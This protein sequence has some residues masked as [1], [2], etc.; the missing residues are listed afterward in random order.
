MVEVP[1][2][3]PAAA[4]RRALLGRHRHPV[5]VGL[6]LAVRLFQGSPAPIGQGLAVLGARI[7]HGVFYLL[8]VAV[9]VTGL[10][11]ASMSLRRSG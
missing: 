9:P 5:L 8:L 3:H 7:V 10:L 11:A 6:R 2:H 4:G 1:G